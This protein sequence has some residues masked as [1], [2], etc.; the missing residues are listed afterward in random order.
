VRFNHG[1]SQSL[2]FGGNG[3]GNGNGNG[4]IGWLEQLNKKVALVRS[5][6]WNLLLL[7]PLLVIFCVIFACPELL[8]IPYSMLVTIAYIIHWF[9]YTFPLAG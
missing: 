8:Y 1:F 2:A 7:Y 9:Y 4:S 5:I 3:N 6:V